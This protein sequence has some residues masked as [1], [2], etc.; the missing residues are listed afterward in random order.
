MRE[1]RGGQTLKAGK[2]GAVNCIRQQILLPGETANVSLKGNVRL[3][4]L[5]ERDSLRINAHLGIFMTPLRWLWPEFPT[6]LREGPETTETV[7]TLSISGLARYGIGSAAGAGVAAPVPAFWRDAVLRVYNEW[8]KWPEDPDVT[9]WPLDGAAAV[10][11][12][13]VWNRLRY[14][15]SPSSANDYTLGS[16]NDFDVRD[17]SALQARFRSSMERDVLSYNRFMELVSEMY[18]GGEG[19][20][21]VDQVPKMIDQ[22]EVGVNPRELPATDAAG[23]GQWQS[24][25]DFGIDHQVR[26]IVCPEHCVL[27]YM[28]TVR[29]APIIEGRHALST[30]PLSWQEMVGDPEMLRSMA[31][32]PVTVGEVATE[33]VAATQLGYAPAGWQWRTGHDVVGSRIDARN[34]FPYM[35]SPSTQENAK[36]ATR[37]RP[38]FRSSSLGDYMVDLYVSESTRSPI[39]GSLESYFSGMTGK[40]SDAEFPKQGKML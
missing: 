6:Y 27:T 8:Y 5:R 14:D 2:I 26:G 19:S 36:D 9:A 34:S 25:F 28:L 12:Q 37:V 10:P 31:P 33:G 20:R 7:P 24:I 40:G 21:E 32:V 13:H 39:A 11:L 29:F 4:S 1:D 30:V 35:L 15:A 38:A 18:R 3:E 22:V 16:V 17:L 23:L